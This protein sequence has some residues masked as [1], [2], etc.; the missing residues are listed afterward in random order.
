MEKKDG[1]MGVGKEGG[2]GGEGGR[3]GARRGVREGGGRKEEMGR[4][5]KERK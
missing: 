5:M 2:V 4:N 1:K 3:K